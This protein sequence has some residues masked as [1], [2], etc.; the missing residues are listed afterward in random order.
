MVIV[1]SLL[2][3]ILHAMIEMIFINLEAEAC[4]TTLMHYFIVCFNA[5]FG[6]VPFS[7][8]FSTSSGY[9][10][11]EK[12]SQEDLDYEDMNSSLLG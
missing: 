6:W 12:Y 8:Q 5:R 1:F 9:Q 3:A 11:P 4:K 2:A 10:L 7:D